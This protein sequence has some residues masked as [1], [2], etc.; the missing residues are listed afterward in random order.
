MTIKEELREKLRQAKAKQ[1]AD[2][3]AVEEEARKMIDEFIIP[4]FRQIATEKPAAEYLFIEMFDCLDSKWFYTS[5][6][7][8]CEEM[9]LIPYDRD[10]IFAAT[11]LAKKQD[12]EVVMCE[13]S[14]LPN[15]KF[16]LDLQ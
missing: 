4:K 14:F 7:D 16:I 15:I 9:K 13:D 11:N 8:T 6:I 5:N 2:E 10:V 1:W 3:Q 12:I